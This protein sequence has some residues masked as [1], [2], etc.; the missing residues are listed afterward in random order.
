MVMKLKRSLYGLSQSPTLRYDT[1]DVALLGIGFTP[2]SSDP[3]VFTRGSNDTCAMLTL[4]LDDILISRS[5]H[6]VVKRLKKA[7]M[8]R[9]A[10]TDMGEVSLILAMNVTRSYEEGTFTSTQNITSRT[11]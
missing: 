3:C 2:T 6:G 10:M 9:F 4:C 7:L 8:D 5:N 1:I 11:S